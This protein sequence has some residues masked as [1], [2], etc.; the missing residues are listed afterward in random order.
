MVCH[1]AGAMLIEDALCIW[2]SDGRPV[3]FAGDERQLPPTVT[4]VGA[5]P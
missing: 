5:L 2:F 4:N 1:E 3:S